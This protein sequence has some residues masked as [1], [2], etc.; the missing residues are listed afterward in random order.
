MIQFYTFYYI[1]LT[2]DQKPNRIMFI[3]VVYCFFQY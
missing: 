1:E 2:V 3:C